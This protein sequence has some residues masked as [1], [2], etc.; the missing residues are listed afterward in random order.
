MAR[1]CYT[2]PWL[3]NCI[4]L[5]RAKRAAARIS[6]LQVGP[7]KSIRGTRWRSTAGR[8]NART[9]PPPPIRPSSRSHQRRRFRIYTLRNVAK[10][11]RDTN[12]A[13]KIQ[14]DPDFY[15]RPFCFACAN[16]TYKIGTASICTSPTRIKATSRSTC[17][18]PALRTRS[19]KKR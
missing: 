9:P 14:C 4:A 3:A 18:W 13:Q 17:T 5:R 1:R 19:R 2:D 12:A 6:T 10:K 7:I 15:W 11:V 16:Y 8:C